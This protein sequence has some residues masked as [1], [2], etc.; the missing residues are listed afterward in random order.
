M[1]DYYFFEE[2]RH[3]LLD[4]LVFG[5]LASVEEVVEVVSEL[6]DFVGGSL[7]GLDEL[8]A[9]IEMF[10]QVTHWIVLR[11]TIVINYYSGQQS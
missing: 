9:E 2:D 6:L 8:L 11:D 10:H 5:L 4:L 3:Q 1:L 7:A